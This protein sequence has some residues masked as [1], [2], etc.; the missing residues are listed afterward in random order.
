MIE[1]ITRLTPQQVFLIQGNQDFYKTLL[2]TLEESVSTV[3]RIATA[4]FTMEDART[5][6]SW[7]N[8]HAGSEDWLLVYF[9]IFVPD[10]AQVLLKTLE[11][12]GRNVRIV[13][14]TEHPYLIPQTIRS[15][16]RLLLGTQSED[17]V[18]PEYVQSKKALTEYIKETL[19][20]EEGDVSER[21]AIAAHLL[22]LLEHKS[23]KDTEKLRH[24]YRAKEMLYKANMPTK[25]VV[26]YVAAM[27]F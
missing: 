2:T 1:T 15:R 11:E 4:R 19:A 21:R 5:V 23:K 9:D 25:Q 20:G 22:D 3:E 14:I 8:D 12:P 7:N 17:L 6:V 27:L 10:A 16:V 24:I 18:L 26:E 13:L